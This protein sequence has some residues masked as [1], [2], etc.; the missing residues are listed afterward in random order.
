[1]EIDV[2]VIGATGFT[3][4]EIV[5]LLHFH[6]KV[7][8][9]YV[10]SRKLMGKYVSSR[11]PNLRTITNLKYES[12][13][14]EKAK[15]K[16]DYLFL[17][18]PHTVSQD[19]VPPIL[20]AGLKVIDLSAD[21]RLKDKEL[22]KYYY[23]KEHTSPEFLERSVYGL[24][25]IHRSE[26]K[27]ADL[28]AVAGCHAASAIY[29]LFPLIKEDLIL[30]DK[31]IVDSKT[32]SSGSGAEV[33]ESSHHPI[34]ANSIRPYKMT[35]HR[36]T[37]EIEQEL[38]IAIRDKNKKNLINIGFSA[39]AVNIIRGILSTCHVFYDKS[40]KIDEK[41][42]FKCYR[43][44]YK[45]EP[46]VRIIKQASGIFR[47]PDPKIIAGTNYVDIGF[48]LDPHSNR[49]VVLSTL[50]NIIKGAVGNAIQCLNI[51]TNIDEK[52]GLEFPGF[53]P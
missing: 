42:L 11:N 44:V 10:T 1:M 52:T 41:V 3:G 49:I 13:S 50:D 23:K 19:M 26:I 48:E 33:S 16:C 9:T 37:A 43:S 25:E 14:V 53:F 36:H 5:R 38:A 17:C 21:Y 51:M 7:N 34:R 15:E 8:L 12:Y 22:Y 18:V 39:H 28:V 20:E 4:G 27:S 45:D 47:L 2:G 46:F 30:L 29:A 24:P 32:G 35:N 40:N 6:P 31:I